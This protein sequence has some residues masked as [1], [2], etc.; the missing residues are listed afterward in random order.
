ML[1]KSEK[2]RWRTVILHSI[3]LGLIIMLAYPVMGASFLLHKSSG[4]DRSITSLLGGG[5]LSGISYLS[6]YLIGRA[7]F[8][9]YFMDGE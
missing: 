4:I 8:P 3:A 1:F 2:H 5:V 9:Q 6:A 7:F